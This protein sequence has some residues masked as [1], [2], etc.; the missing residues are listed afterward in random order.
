MCQYGCPEITEEWRTVD[1]FPMYEVSNLG[2]VRSIARRVEDSRG[3]RYNRSARVLTNVP[4]DHGYP[5]VPLYSADRDRPFTR[6]VHVLVNTA[7]HGDKPLGPTVFETRHLDGNSMH[8]C[9]TNLAWGTKSENMQDMLAHGTH[10]QTCKTRCPRGHIMA[11]ANIKA[12]RAREG[13]RECLACDRAK[14]RT[15]QRFVRAGRKAEFSPN[16][17]EVIELADQIFAEIVTDSVKTYVVAAHIVR[18]FLPQVRAEL[19][20]AA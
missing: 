13:R 16:L 6:S 20:V 1:A 5:Q 4:N 2:R 17:P 9:E 10:W 15:Y 11:G 3:R 14:S 7:F 12:V 19:E 8:A 18:R